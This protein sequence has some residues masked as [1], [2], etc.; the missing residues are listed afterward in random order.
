MKRLIIFVVLVIL[1]FL[2]MQGCYTQR[3]TVGTGGT[4]TEV[5]EKK[6]WYALWGLVPM[7]EFDAS[8]LA[9]GVTDYTV[10]YEMTFVDGI[11]S[12]FTGIVTISP[13]T[14]RVYK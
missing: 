7:N 11:V 8:E 13:R 4:D 1:L 9:E 3:V 2:P 14:V 6:S 10:E 12:I 5:V